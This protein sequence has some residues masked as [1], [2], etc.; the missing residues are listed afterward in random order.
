M[1][2]TCKPDASS[3]SYQVYGIQSASVSARSTAIFD[4]AAGA[5]R[6]YFSMQ[7]YSKLAGG[8]QGKDKKNGTVIGAGF[9][10]NVHRDLKN[11]RATQTAT[12][13]ATQLGLH[14]NLGLQYSLDATPIGQCT[15]TPYNDPYPS[16]GTTRFAIS[17]LD[18]AFLVSIF[19]L[20]EF[21][22]Y[23]ANGLPTGNFVRCIIDSAGFVIRVMF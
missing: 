8:L 4:D 21:V 22:D 16:R 10:A 23:F 14:T 6:D 12:A 19:T 13:T 9:C 5:C 18:R 7:G 2:T 3:Y 20:R 1:K 17:R 15:A 11:L